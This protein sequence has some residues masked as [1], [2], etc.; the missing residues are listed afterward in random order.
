MCF[1]GGQLHASLV[2]QEH[3]HDAVELVT[4]HK[5]QPHLELSTDDPLAMCFIGEQSLAAH[6]VTVII[7]TM[8]SRPGPPY[9]SFCACPD[10]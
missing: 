5:P 9:I 2:L 6:G 7:I 8:W 3:E 4:H 10:G 1:V